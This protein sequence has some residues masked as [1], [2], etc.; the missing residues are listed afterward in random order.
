M[1]ILLDFLLSGRTAADYYNIQA[2]PRAPVRPEGVDG[3]GWQV[4]MKAGAATRHW[5]RVEHILRILTAALPDATPADTP[6]DEGVSAGG[7]W[8][9]TPQA[10]TAALLLRLEE[11]GI[12]GHGGLGLPGGDRA[13]ARLPVLRG[14]PKH[15]A[16]SGAAWDAAIRGAR[17]AL[18]GA[19]GATVSPG[20]LFEAELSDGRVFATSSR[21]VA[22]HRKW[23][24]AECRRQ[25]DAMG[26]PEGLSHPDWEKHVRA[27]AADLAALTG[28][29]HLAARL[30]ND[31][32]LGEEADGWKRIPHWLLCPDGA[33]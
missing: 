31:L 10:A 22:S 20:T 4:V 25:L 5:A 29:G 13:S 2:P 16:D 15:R 26:R 9:T 28:P 7:V 27:W 32:R 19:L 14:V 23:F 8:F 12:G 17:E 30:I 21:V 3:E 1:S 24:A 11:Q 18:E 33:L 6:E